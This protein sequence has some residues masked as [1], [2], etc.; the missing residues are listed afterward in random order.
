MSEHWGEEWLPEVERLP[1]ICGGLH[2]L[3][4]D[5]PSHMDEVTGE[6]VYL[7]VAIPLL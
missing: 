6:D 5:P 2:R 4:E 7:M 3:S 1:Q